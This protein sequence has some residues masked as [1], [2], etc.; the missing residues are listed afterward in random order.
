MIRDSYSKA[1]VATDVNELQQYRSQ[2]KR[3]RELLQIKE[4]IKSIKNCI[5]R[6]SESLEK[7][8]S[9]YGKN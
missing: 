9:R 8:E 4:D 1:L 2:K 5:N 7:L 6:M 3:E